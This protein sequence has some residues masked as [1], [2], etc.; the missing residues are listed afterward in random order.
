LTN[1]ETTR[2]FNENLR[3][4]NRGDALIINQGGTSSGKTYA[5]LQV[6]IMIALSSSKSLVISVVSET[7]PHLR[8]GAMRDFFHII[9][10]MY[11]PSCHNKTDLIYTINNSRIEF[12]AADNDSK[13]RGARR[14]ILFINEANN[15]R[16]AAFDQL[17]PR[18]KGATFIDFNP[19]HWF[20][21]HDLMNEDGVTFIR[22][23]YKDNPMLGEKVIRS[24]ER[25]KDKDPNWWR[26][27]GEG[28]IGIADDLVFSNWQQVDR[29]LGG[30]FWCGMDFGYTNDP[31][32]IVRIAVEG[33]DLYV[34]EMLYRTGMMNPQIAE[35]CVQQL[36]KFTEVFADSAEPKSIDE[37]YAY[38]VNI[39]PVAKGKDSI[40]H[41]ID[42]LH[43]YNLKITNDFE[44]LRAIIIN[45]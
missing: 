43:R 45:T 28:E 5:I 40:T 20:Y 25:R 6:L 17:E 38:G 8:R 11:D 35:Y 2:I 24:I 39:H 44:E 32:T 37:I 27:Y 33:D 19:T 30:P 22:S 15:I 29:F 34:D 23:T 10:D 16:K 7:M 4:Y 14:D 41:G 3:A 12:F 13:M 21:A 26:V 1:L 18:T 9:G 42:I 31:S 36:P